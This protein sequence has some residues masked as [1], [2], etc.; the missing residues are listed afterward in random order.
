MKKLSEN[1]IKS[2]S[3][4]NFFLFLTLKKEKK[5]KEYPQSFEIF[6]IRL[7]I[8]GR[9]KKFRLMIHVRGNAQ[10]I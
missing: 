10:Y 1:E 8:I 6:R 2:D 7:K 4:L 9:E 3:L 5:E